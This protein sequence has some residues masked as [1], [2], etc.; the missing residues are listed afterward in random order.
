MNSSMQGALADLRV[1]ELSNERS[2][3]AGK[4]LAD[5]GADV[6]L[7]EPPGGD[8]MRSYAPFLEDEA[9]PERSLYF[10]HYNTSKRGIVLDLEAEDGRRMLRELVETAD[11][12]LESEPPGRLEALGIDAASLRAERPDL[13]TVSMAPFMRGGPR[14]HEQATDL[15]LLAGGGPAWSSGYDDHS[16]PPVRGGGN[17]GYQTGCH[18]AV[19]ALM[20]AVVSRDIT[21][22]GQHIDVDMH[23]AQ[24]VTNEA[25]SYT[26]LVAQETVQ[27]QTGRHAGV[28]PSAP[29]QVQCSD[30]RWVN[31][32]VPARQ[33]RDYRAL[34][35]WLGE[36]GLLEDFA[37]APLL[38]LGAG[39]GRID[40]SQIATN[41][42]VRETFQAGRD[43][44]V[45][46]AS[47]MPAYDF[48]SGGQDR[49][50][51]VGIIYS[52]EEVMEDPHFIDRGFRV[53]VEHPD[54]GRSF[55]YP[56]APYLFHDS[57]WQI[58][59]RAPLLGEHQ[60]EV[61]DEIGYG[62]V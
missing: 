33:G 11:V 8:L 42:E 16:L 25:G 34:I 15:T 6:I 59:R 30:G 49:G 52:P 37:A 2:V 54:L 61:L 3:F 35:D 51:Q 21:G 10:W 4:L 20:V 31:T 27:R 44:L 7:V 26:W 36:C 14:E 13:I 32:G 19:M 23:A 38:E 5:M 12:L 17:Q 60:A 62:A 24:N 39:Q 22:T 28:N 53:E 58:Q 46:L 41:P 43:A 57:P 48:F 1:I 29:S 47:S 55:T 50:F 9:G 56:G 45:L 18:Y 40:L